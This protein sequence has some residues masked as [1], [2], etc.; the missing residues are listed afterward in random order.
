MTVSLLLLLC[1]LASLLIVPLLVSLRHSGIAGIPAYVGGAA[2]S[3]M[4]M[5]MFVSSNLT[6]LLWHGLVANLLLAGAMGLF[7]VGVRQ[8]FALPAH[9]AA[10]TGALAGLTLAMLCFTFAHNSPLARLLVFCALATT[11]KLLTGLTVVRMR[12]RVASRGPWVFA[13]LAAFAMAA[14]FMVRGFSGVQS[15]KAPWWIDHTHVS[16]IVF[17]MVVCTTLPATLLGMVMLVQ[18]RIIET[19][20]SALTFDDLT[21]AYSRRSF[22]SEVQ[23]ELTRGRRSGRPAVLLALDIDRFKSI[24]DSYGHAAGDAALRHFAESVKGIIRPGDRFGRLGGEEFAVLICDTDLTGAQLQA[25]RIRAT[26][27]SSPLRTH[28]KIIALTV[29]G[30]L[31]A[32]RLDDTPAT[33]LARA[34][35][36]LYRA[37]RLG[38]DRMENDIMQDSRPPSAPTATPPS[39]AAPPAQP[40]SADTAPDDNGLL[41]RR[42][43]ERKGHGHGATRH[44]EP[45]P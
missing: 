12:H 5:L 16:N 15:A 9:G 39:N 6:A 13:A 14:A 33:L 27:A 2:L 17:A 38:R 24:N 40:P 23:V 44:D 1:G 31:S 7:Y 10:L 3:A 41:I 29:S 18:S 20:R 45:K 28:G 42:G 43:R 22:L 21:G 11:I 36:A 37:K 34:D 4:A 19:M 26:V 30:G 8:F 25:Q 35:A 32:C